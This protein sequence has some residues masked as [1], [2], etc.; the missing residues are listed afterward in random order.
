MARSLIYLSAYASGLQVQ[1]WKPERAKNSSVI[2]IL[3]EAGPFYTKKGKVI[4][5][6]AGTGAILGGVPVVGFMNQS[7][8][9]IR[10]KYVAS[11]LQSAGL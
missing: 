11:L 1:V 5:V 9:H 8:L 4:K 10:S 6:T 7:L 2:V 3:K